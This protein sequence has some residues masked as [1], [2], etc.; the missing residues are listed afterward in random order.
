MSYELPLYR[1][2]L[3]QYLEAIHGQH[4]N[5]ALLSPNTAPGLHDD[6]PAYTTNHQCTVG[7]N[8]PVANCSTETRLSFRGNAILVGTAFHTAHPGAASRRADIVHNTRAIDIQKQ[9]SFAL[10]LIHHHAIQPAESPT[11]WFSTS[12]I[13]DYSGDSDAVVDLP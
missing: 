1:D 13:P 8:I 3:T 9:Q 11:A 6:H 7:G 4:I 10:C 5:S 2:V 12:D